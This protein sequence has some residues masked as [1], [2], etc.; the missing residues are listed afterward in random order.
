M[1]RGL[2]ITTVV[3]FLVA[4]VCLGGV[5]MLGG[6]NWHGRSWS[7]DSD[8]HCTWSPDHRTKTCVGSFGHAGDK[9]HEPEGVRNYA[10]AGGDTLVV[11]APGKIHYV[12]GPA[13]AV[14]IEGPEALLKRLTFKDGEI[15]LTG[16]GLRRASGL[17]IT[18][19]APSVTSFR[20]N[21]AQKIDIDDYAQDLL[22]IEG[23]GAVDLEAK[24]TARKIELRMNGASN[25]DL[26]EVINDEAK[27]ELNGASNASL[28]PKVSVDI[29]I[30]GVG[31]VSL[32]SDPPHATKEIHGLGSV[33][34]PMGGDG[35][36]T[37]PPPPP[38]A[39]ATARPIRR[40]VATDA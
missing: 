26:D 20:F 16:R 1:I 8:K 4:V 17:D 29:R 21:G 6:P 35:E 15:D 11:N 34:G 25:A 3:S 14:K 37:S 12:Q 19:E 39:P 23:N 38:T 32:A 18:I 36:E 27:V 2:L 28:A 13:S 9:D 33:S 24:G 40:G 31:N 5:A 10:W 7:V 30:N 22:Q